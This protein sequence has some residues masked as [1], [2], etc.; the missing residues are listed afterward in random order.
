MGLKNIVFSGGGL[1]GWAYIG[2]IKALNELINFKEIEQ[3][4]GVSVGSAFGLFYLLNLKWEYLLDYIMNLNFK[5][6]IDI[7]IDNFFTTQ[8][9]LHGH[10]FKNTLKEIMS[11]K[12]DPDIT[13][14][15]LRKY[16]KILF[17][18]VALNITESKIEYFNYNLT[19]DV[20]LIDAL[21]ASCCLPLLFPSYQINF[22]YYYDGGICNNCPNNLVD[23]LNSVSFDLGEAN[24]TLSN[25]K[26]VNLIMCLINISNEISK[27]EHNGNKLLFHILDSE[28]RN[29]MININQSRDRIFNIFMN[30]YTNSYNILFDNFIALK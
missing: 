15:E 11:Q 30:G 12:I 18:T 19:P 7:D 16:S 10:I 13:F 14:I 9:L 28:F 26:L 8:S 20:K 17:T 21:M 2:T 3:I 27:N 22:N 4:V 6:M 1:K 23:E 25:N 5:E 29:E 24:D